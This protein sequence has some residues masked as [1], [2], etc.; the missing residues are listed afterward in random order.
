[1]S[2]GS[3]TSLKGI[4]KRSRLGSIAGRIAAERG[5][6]IRRLS[7]RRD[8]P[9]GATHY[10]FSLERSIAYIDQ[11]FDDYVRYG[12]LGGDAL[13]GKRVLELGPGDNFGV[14]LL[15][16]A[17]GAERIV[18]TDR[19]IP[20]RDPA[21]QRQ[22]YEALLAR[23]TQAQ[24]ARVA[25]VDP[26]AA[27]PFAGAP[28]DALEETPIEEAAGILGAESFDLV[29]SRAVLE[30]V[31]DLGRAFDA[32][33]TMLVPGGRMLHKVDLE[34]HGLFSEGGQNPL[35]FLTVSDRV[36]S[37]MGEESAGLP[38]RVPIGWYLTEMER[39]G[40][41]ARFL[42][43]NLIGSEGELPAFEPMT[44]TVIDERSRQLTRE[45][46]GGLKPRFRGWSDEDL[47]ISGF[48]LD[49]RKPV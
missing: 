10:S 45:I 41:E 27:D 1:V 21:R 14:A 46:R 30:H 5:R 40:Y 3:P 6:D 48:L 15:L 23:M 12:D 47:A 4:A 17:A 49:A 9:M 8:N 26:A 16:L 36:Y 19:F 31:G 34:D 43:T 42:V 37:W 33:D 18:V 39:R 7:G 24:R 38:N 22:I 35:T 25:G 28:L 11:V 20:Y 44:N 2:E 13:A 32:M 29:I